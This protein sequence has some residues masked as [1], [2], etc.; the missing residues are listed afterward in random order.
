MHIRSYWVEHGIVTGGQ[1]GSQSGCQPYTLPK[2]EHH[3]AGKY[4]NCSDGS[5]TPKC[6]KQCDKQY[7]ETYRQ[8][9][10]Y[11]KKCYYVDSPVKAIA[12]EI[13]TNGPVESA[14][15]VYA[16]FLTYKSGEL[17]HNFLKECMTPT[18]THPN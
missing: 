3:D 11:G 12:T 9:L 15:A 2:C 18:A 10:H 16:D 5:T 14:F 17:C 13:M 8:D 7:K 6:S 1:Y 4:P